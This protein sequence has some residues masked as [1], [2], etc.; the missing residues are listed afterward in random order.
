MGWAWKDEVGPLPKSLLPGPQ[1]FWLPWLLQDPV[2]PL[3]TLQDRGPN[4]T[5]P[6]LEFLSP[7]AVTSSILSRNCLRLQPR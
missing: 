3:L 5:L 2:T 6:V 1:I 7:S 4:P